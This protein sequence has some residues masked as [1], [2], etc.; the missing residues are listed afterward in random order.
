MIAILKRLF[1]R[2]SKSYRELILQE[3][4]RV[5]FYPLGEVTYR[6]SIELSQH[7]PTKRKD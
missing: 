3:P 6:C 4:G 2:K 1:R 5:A 7:Q